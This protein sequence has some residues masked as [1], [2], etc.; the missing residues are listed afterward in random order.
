MRFAHEAEEG[1]YLAEDPSFTGCVT[2]GE[3]L[4]ERLKSLVE[5]VEGWLTVEIE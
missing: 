4:E 5:A 3:T 2:P 1:G